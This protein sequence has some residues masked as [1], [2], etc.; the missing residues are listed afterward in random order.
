MLAPWDHRNHDVANALLVHMERGGACEQLLRPIARI[1]VQ[2][3]PT[4]QQFVLEIGE[5]RTRRCLPR[6]ILSANTQCNPIPLGHD[7]RSRPDF[8]GQIN[9]LA[10]LHWPNLVMGVVGT[11]RPGQGLIELAMRGAQ[12]TL[13]DWR[14]R[15]DG[16]SEGDLAQIGTKDT[17]HDKDIGVLGGRLQGKRLTPGIEIEP[18]P[19]RRAQRPVGLKPLN[20]AIDVA[21]LKLDPGLFRPAVGF[22]LEVEI[23]ESLLQAPPVVG[24]K[25]RPML[26]A[27]ALEPLLL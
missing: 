17:E 8:D 15:I 19:S 13:R 10:R 3:W 5:F 20:E 9:R 18:G 12:P 27:V 25:M 22:A 23:E 21:H 24:V 14:M 26:E 7:D 2:E 16:A 6:I 1:I 4:S 11:V